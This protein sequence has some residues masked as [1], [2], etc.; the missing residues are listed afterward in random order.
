M[1]EAAKNIKFETNI[2][3]DLDISSIQPNPYQPRTHFDEKAID[4]LAESIKQSGLHEPILFCVDADGDPV[5][6][7]GER[8]LRAHK[9][10]KKET[11]PARLTEADPKEVSLIENIVREDI[12]A[13]EESAAIKALIDEHNYTQKKIAGIIGKSEPT[14]SEILSIKSKIPT[15]LFNDIKTKN[16]TCPRWIL[17][18]VAK[19]TETK[20][21]RAVYN[22]FDKKGLTREKFR[23]G[24]QTKANPKQPIYIAN[25]LA[26]KLEKI[27]FNGWE[28]KDKD[29]LSDSLKNLQSAITRVLKKK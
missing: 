29:T 22:R 5:L 18:E 6:V 9:K 17:L 28:E 4:E 19:Q 14:V 15:R 20:K 24:K 16:P 13:I 12:T 27:D 10:L 26:K 1:S 2:V 23:K 11:I 21:Q 25:D 3:Y 7:A 8:R